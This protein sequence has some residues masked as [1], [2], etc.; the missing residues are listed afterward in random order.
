MEGVFPQFESR[1]HVELGEQANG[2]TIYQQFS[3]C[4]EDFHDHMFDSLE[5]LEDL[6]LEDMA[7]LGKVCAGGIHL[8]A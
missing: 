5:K 4:R 6:T 7:R 8:A 3:A 1:H 2:M